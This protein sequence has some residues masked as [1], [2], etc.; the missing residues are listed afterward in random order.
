MK[1]WP[2]ITEG[3]LTP[4]YGRQYSSA[5]A[6]EEDF[7]LGKDFHWN[8]PLG[9][10]YCSIRDY[11]PGSQAKIRYNAKRDVMFVKVTEEN[12]RLLP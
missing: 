9:D 2:P 7:L 4:A 11:P 5:I 8:H 3:T 1:K 10:T 12:Q 6:V